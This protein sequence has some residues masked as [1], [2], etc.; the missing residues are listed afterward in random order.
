MHVD[1]FTEAYRAIHEERCDILTQRRVR[2]QGELPGAL[3]HIFAPRDADKIRDLLNKVAIEK[4][5]W[6]FTK[7]EV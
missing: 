2:V 5:E 3:W 7:N 4:G 1:W 6:D